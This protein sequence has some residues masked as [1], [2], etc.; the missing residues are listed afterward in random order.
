MNAPLRPYRLVSRGGAGLACD[1]DGL[2]LGGADLARATRE[3]RGAARCDVRSPA[4]IARILRAA[5]GPQTDAEVLRVHRG[6]CGTAASIEAGYLAH[7]GIEAVM[8]ALPDLTPEALAKLAEIADL[9]KGENDA[10]ENEPRIAGGQTGGGQWTTGGTPRAP[11]TNGSARGSRQ[12][13]P[14]RRPLPVHSGGARESAST[15]EDAKSSEVIDQNLPAPV[16]TAGAVVGGRGTV[17]DFALPEGGARVGRAGL[18]A[19]A[20]SLLDQWDAA[21]ARDQITKAM[22]RFGL[23]PAR[24]ADV[25]AAGAYVWSRYALPL[26]TEAPFSGPKL[27]AASQAVCASC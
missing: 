16:S 8:L 19:F 6:L 11:A 5:Y 26:L 20:A 1:Q 25:M 22:A 2:A 13:P 23:D 7:A 14:A 21:N 15:S 27:D 10:W 12:A 17:G 9:E 18:L 24:P 4:E 3:A